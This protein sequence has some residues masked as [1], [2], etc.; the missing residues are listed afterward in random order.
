MKLTTAITIEHIN[1]FVPFT[2]SFPPSL[3]SDKQSRKDSAISQ[4][5][6]SI[7]FRSLHKLLLG[8]ETLSISVRIE[9]WIINEKR[10]ISP[11]A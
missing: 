10:I 5:M 2:K 3:I 4:S 11:I 9:S 6:P 8:S 7:L 1:K